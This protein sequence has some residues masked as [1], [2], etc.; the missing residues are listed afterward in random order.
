M[1]QKYYTFSQPILYE[2]KYTI[3]NNY[4]LINKLQGLKSIQVYIIVKYRFLFI[5]DFWK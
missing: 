3:K 1:R 2:K 4:R 5:H